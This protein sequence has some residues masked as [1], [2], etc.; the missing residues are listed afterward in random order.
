M[1]TK[2][3][4]SKLDSYRSR[5]P[6]TL[7]ETWFEEAASTETVNFDAAQL[8]TVDDTGMP[9]IRTV[10]VRERGKDGFVFYTNLNSKKGQELVANKKAALLFY[11]KSLSRQI[12]IR[13]TV[14]QVSDPEADAY[15]S[16]RPQMS[17]IGAHVSRQSEPLADR[18]HLEKMITRF[19]EYNIGKTI[20]RPAH[21]SGFR[22]MPLEI[23]FW[24]EGE[25]RL[26]DR[27]LFEKKSTGWYRTLLYP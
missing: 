21:W 8:A 2:E 16:T 9:N 23:E 19:K 1:K 10:L 14:S 12:R 20:T 15:F 26:H 4:K 27:L 17:C 13:G 7:L 3:Y 5:L 6:F 25:H 11:W 22:I 18:S 24:E